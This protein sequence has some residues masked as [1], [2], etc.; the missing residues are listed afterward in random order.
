MA[1]G[2]EEIHGG[3]LLMFENIKN[4]GGCLY[5]IRRCGYFYVWEG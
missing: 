3:I 1:R 5:S 2:V 4:N